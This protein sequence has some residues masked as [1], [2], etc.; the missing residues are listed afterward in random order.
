MIFD[1]NEKKGDA[2][3]RVHHLARNDIIKILLISAPFLACLPYYVFLFHQ[4]Y[5]ASSIGNKAALPGASMIFGA[6]FFFTYAAAWSRHWLFRIVMASIFFFGS[7]VFFA[8][9]KSTGAPATFNAISMLFDS[10]DAAPDAWSLYYRQIIAASTIACFTFIGVILPGTPYRNH[11]VAPLTLLV[12]AGLAVLSVY[13]NGSG[14]GSAAPGWA[15]P[16][17]T[18]LVLYDHAMAPVSRNK[19]PIPASGRAPRGDIVILVDESIGG[20]YL[21]IN[22]PSGARSGLKNLL[23]KGD[24]ANFGIAASATNF[25]VGSNFIMRTGGTRANYQQRAASIWSYGHRAGYRTVYL[26]GQSYDG[27]QNLMTRGEQKEIDDYILLKR[28]SREQRDAA[29]ARIVRRLLH[30]GVPE[31]VYVNKSGAH[32]PAWT[33]YPLRQTVYKPNLS[34]YIKDGTA[35]IDVFDISTR[36]RYINDYCNSIEWNVGKFFDSALQDG[37]PAGSTIIYTSDHGEALGNRS[38]LLFGH[39]RSDGP[40]PEEGA[41]PMVVISAPGEGARWVSAAAS[42]RG[43]SH[44]QV[45]PTILQLM[46]YDKGRVASSFGSALDASAGDPLTFNSN[47]YTRFGTA[48][49]WHKIH[50]DDLRHACNKQ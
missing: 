14:L 6:T 40:A 7:F 12:F 45:F 33:T 15:A 27:L 31:L 26:Y 2:E 30:N 19:Q 5:Q 16:L 10:R 47:F 36:K 3:A 28:F 39:G 1:K 38:P 18:G 44:Y 17:Y 48:Q 41:V 50:K 32:F 37:L 20:Q 49:A 21:D 25:S 46:G 9:W 13:R 22:S 43:A 8:L 29:A 11:W 24:T 23:D 42:G 34:S 4:Y 35:A